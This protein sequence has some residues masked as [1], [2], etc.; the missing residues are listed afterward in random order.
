M[1]RP[2][3]GGVRRDSPKAQAEAY[4]TSVVSCNQFQRGCGCRRTSYPVP[5]CAPL[6]LDGRSQGRFRCSNS[7]ISG[8]KLAQRAYW[9]VGAI[10]RFARNLKQ[11][12]R[13]SPAPLG[14]FV[15]KRHHRT[16][17]FNTGL[18][19]HLVGRPDRR[20]KL[21]VLEGREVIVG[22]PQIQAGVFACRSVL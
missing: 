19:D 17:D 3:P 12:G 4:T 6:C 10:G 14:G 15:A 5:D 13:K 21:R 1:S 18:T 22:S 20:P 9:P 2:R 8:K 7:P 16:K 11:T